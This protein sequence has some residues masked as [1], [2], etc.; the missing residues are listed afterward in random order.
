MNGQCKTCDSNVGPIST[1]HFD[2]SRVIS[3]CQTEF[4]K[5]LYSRHI[6]TR[7]CLGENYMLL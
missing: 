3:P 7:T 4:L 5:D 1:P 6:K 2:P